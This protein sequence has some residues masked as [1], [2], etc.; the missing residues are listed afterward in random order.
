MGGALGDLV[1]HGVQAHSSTGT[2][3]NA[4][5]A[6]IPFLAEMKTLFDRLLTDR[7]LQDDGYDPPFSDFNPV[8]D[9]HGTAIN[10]A[11]SLSSS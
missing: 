6:L 1:A 7:S 8:I 5:W 2:G 4:N 9:N 11:A 3:R 10:D